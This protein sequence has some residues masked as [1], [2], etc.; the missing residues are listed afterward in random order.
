[1][2]KL[3]LVKET[4]MQVVPCLIIHTGFLDY[5]YLKE[6]CKLII[7]GVSKQQRLYANPEGIQKIN[8]TYN[9]ECYSLLEKIEIVTRNV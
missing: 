9:L 8:F 5:P 4:P 7:I 1:M 3:P 2:K 6:N